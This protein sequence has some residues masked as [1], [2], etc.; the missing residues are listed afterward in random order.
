MQA[1]VEPHVPE[2]RRKITFALRIFW[3]TLNLYSTELEHLETCILDQGM[4]LFV[5]FFSSF[6]IYICSL[7]MSDMTNHHLLWTNLCG[8]RCAC[9]VILIWNGRANLPWFTPKWFL[10][11][12]QS[13]VVVSQVLFCAPLPTLL[14]WKSDGPGESTQY[15]KAQRAVI[16]QRTRW[17]PPP[18]SI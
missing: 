1:S 15:N 9:E 3:I 10:F 14:F 7:H 18:F 4:A 11:I 8:S 12:T 2:K 6:F 17:Q 13:E 5:G 16:Y